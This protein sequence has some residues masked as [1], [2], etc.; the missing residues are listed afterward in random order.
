M[1]IASRIQTSIL[2]R[3]FE[4][5]GLQ[6]AAQMIP[7]TQVGGDYYDVLP[8]DGGCWLAIGD[9][10]GH[11]LTAG[12]VMLMIQSIV[13]ALTRQRPDA[14]PAELLSILNEVLFENVRR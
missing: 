11:G 13:S 9:V 4:V 1:E 6:I 5:D 2:P 7:A 14:T 8:V 10:A 3:Q 12:L